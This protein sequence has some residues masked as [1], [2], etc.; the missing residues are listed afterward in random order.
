[1]KADTVHVRV[2]S[3]I[4]RWLD[5]SAMALGLRVSDIVRMIIM[6]AYRVGQYAVEGEHSA[7]PVT[8]P[9]ATPAALY[10]LCGPLVAPRAVDAPPTPCRPRRRSTRAVVAK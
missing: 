8:R 6:D 1:M 2:D 10:P 7:H 3:H 4:R 9:P 5:Q